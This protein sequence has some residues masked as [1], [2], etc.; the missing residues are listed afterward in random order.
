M[1]RKPKLPLL[2]YYEGEVY[3]CKTIKELYLRVT[4]S[5]KA[6]KLKIYDVNGKEFY[7]RESEDSYILSPQFVIKPITKKQLIEYYNGSSKGKID[8][9]IKNFSNIKVDILIKQL[10]DLAR[11]KK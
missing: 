3:G 1:I 2:L 11:A 9:F 8:P 4:N 6:D 10:I 5:M 7:W